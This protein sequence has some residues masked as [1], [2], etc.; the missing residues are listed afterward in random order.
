MPKSLREF[1]AADWRHLRPLTQSVKSW[2]YR[3]VD[4]IYRRRG[5]RAG[6]PEAVAASIH[7]RKVL[8]TVAQ[9]AARAADYVCTVQGGH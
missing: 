3:L 9:F 5:A 4:G 8:V 7:R 1:T 2:R 6:Y